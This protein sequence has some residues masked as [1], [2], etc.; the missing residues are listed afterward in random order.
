MARDTDIREGF[1]ITRVGNVRVDSE[2]E[3]NEA[4]ESA[5]NEKEDGVLIC[6]VYKNVSRNFCYGLTL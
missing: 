5:M 3:F 1:I 4:I 6:G 2:K